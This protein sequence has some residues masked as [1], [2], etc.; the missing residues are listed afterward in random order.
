MERVHENGTRPHVVN[1]LAS[2]KRA[3]FT[4]MIMTKLGADLRTL[5]MVSSRV[6]QTCDV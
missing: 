6:T 2:K 1:L 4:Y 3:S 5:R